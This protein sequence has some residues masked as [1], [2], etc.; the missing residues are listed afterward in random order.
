MLKT[1]LVKDFMI[2]DH[3]SFSPDTDLLNAVS[4]L[5]RHDLS[6]A[7]VVDSEG[8]LVGFLSEKDCLKAALDASYFRRGA[9]PVSDVMSRSVVTVS[10][11][12]TLID[13][14]EIFASKQFRCLP[15]TEGRRL[16]GQISR[17]DV[18]KALEKVRQDAR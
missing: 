6:G 5:L 17:S 10:G 3:L 1:L 2:G 15:V 18:L 16:I 7:P 4:T 8:A 13:V 14:I 9:G 11:D 12:S